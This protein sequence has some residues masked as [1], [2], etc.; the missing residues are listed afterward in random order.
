[1]YKFTITVETFNTSFFNNWTTQ[2]KIIKDI[3]KNQHHHPTGS[4]SSK[5][6]YCNSP[7]M[8][9][10]LSSSMT[11]STIGAGEDSWESL[12]LQGDQTSQS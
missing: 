5:R 9:D 11:I 3:E 4:T 1:M 10:N 7:N 2:Q 8:K 6:Q 12:G